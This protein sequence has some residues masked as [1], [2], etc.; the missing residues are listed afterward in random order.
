MT[1]QWPPSGGRPCA[2]VTTLDDRRRERVAFG[3]LAVA[4]VLLRSFVPTYYEGFYFDSDQAIVG[5]M[6]KHLSSFQRFP[7]FYYGLNYLLAVEA[8]IIAPFFRI[9]RPSVAVMRLPF[10]ALNAV[11]AVWLIGDLTRRLALRPALAFV[12]ALPFVMPT[13]AVGTQLLE[14]AG[15]CVEPFVYV[16]LLWH[17][18]RRP[19]AFGAVLAVG[20]LHREFTIFVVP[21]L[22]LAEAGRER[23]WSRAN[24]ER[25]GWMLAGFAVVWLAIDD[26]RMH[27]SSEPLGLQVASLRGQS[28]L[29]PRELAARFQSLMTTAL[30]TLFGGLPVPLEAFRMSTP[31]VAGYTMLGWMV[32]VALT[33]MIVRLILAR[34]E[35]QRSD[36]ETG[37]GA[38]LAWVGVLAAC[39]YPLS[40]N[41]NIAG[42]PILRYLLLALLLPV[43]CFAAF[44]RHETRAPL[45]H[46][47][48]A[49]FVLWATANLF[50]NVR[51][52]RASVRESPP[53]EH[54]A[55]AD[56][57]VNHQ[58]RYARAIYWDAYVVDFLT[59]ERVVTASVDVVRIPEYQKAV[60]EH[61]DAAVTLVRL[62]CPGP[63]RIASW[64]VQK[65]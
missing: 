43:G 18:R 1:R 33:I 7:L 31:L 21:G 10:V 57:L 54:R 34:G 3:A 35:K 41:V 45:R 26:L 13:P 58:I 50:D 29:D 36:G 44:M 2:L 5:L 11:V 55:L 61:A 15:A 23:L 25:A 48:T 63:E 64:C 40:C 62:P 65:N 51:L 42:A 14:L 46:A 27:L 20:F 22:L 19:L 30:P 4:L 8:W 32:S 47:M 37:F 38:Y 17:L 59:R 53:N 60:D 9:F 49:V 16:L 39:A 28:C 56:Y 6:A 52:V 24:A 12:A